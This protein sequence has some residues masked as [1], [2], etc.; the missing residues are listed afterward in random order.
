MNHLRHFV[1]SNLAISICTISQ[2]HGISL[3]L[4]MKKKTAKQ[5]F[6]FP[7][8][9]QQ[10]NEIYRIKERIWLHD[11]RIIDIGF[12][13]VSL[14]ENLNPLYRFDYIHCN[15][16][17]SHWTCALLSLSDG[18]GWVGG[19]RLFW[20]HVPFNSIFFRNSRPSLGLPYF[21]LHFLSLAFNQQTN[22]P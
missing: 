12:S 13:A 3:S 18:G 1:I 8:A 19:I 4:S 16:S 21:R 2:G 17:R 6:H 5:Y 11:V 15:P 9:N 20:W 14:G 22:C 7:F 10:M